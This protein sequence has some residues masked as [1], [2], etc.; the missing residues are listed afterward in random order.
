MSFYN[1]LLKKLTYLLKESNDPAANITYSMCQRDAYKYLRI[2]I[3]NWSN[4]DGIILCSD[5]LSSPYQSYDNFNKSFI[6]P[7]IYNLL[8]YQRRRVIDNSIDQIANKLGNGDDV[9]LAFILK[10]DSNIKN[11][12][13][14][15]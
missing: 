6:K 9:S 8:K 11:Y 4:Y 12:S 15:S 3:L 2:K 14:Q 7:I 13:D 10:S 5:G 1:E